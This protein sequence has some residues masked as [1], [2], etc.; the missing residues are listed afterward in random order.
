MVNWPFYIVWNINF[1]ILRL[2]ITGTPKPSWTESVQLVFY[3]LTPGKYSTVKLCCSNVPL[4]L[5]RRTPTY[6]HCQ[7]PG[8]KWG[9]CS[10]SSRP[11]PATTARRSQSPPGSSNKQ[12]FYKIC[13]ASSC[14]YKFL[15]WILGQ[16][17]HDWLD[18]VLRR[19]E[20]FTSWPFMSR[21]ETRAGEGGG[22]IL[23]HLDVKIC[24]NLILL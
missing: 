14:L 9:W 24:P 22:D 21:E 5:W 17:F 8:P 12:Q 1:C 3:C 2:V 6:E 16:L 15:L 19:K 7:W 4:E 10:S 11:S 13:P 18:D 23:H 20:H